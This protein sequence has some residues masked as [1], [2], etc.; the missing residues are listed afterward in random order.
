MHIF[1]IQLN[2]SLCITLYYFKVK[3]QWWGSTWIGL[4]V[5]ALLKGTSGNNYSTAINVFLFFLIDVNDYPETASISKC[6]IKGWTLT[7]YTTSR[8]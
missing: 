4:G 7:T 2:D 1:N 6:Y 8:H 3:W 5:S